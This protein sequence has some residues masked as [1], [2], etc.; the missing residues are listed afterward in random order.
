MTTV[1][2]IKDDRLPASPDDWQSEDKRSARR[3]DVMEDDVRVI[4]DELESSHMRIHNAERKVESQKKALM[5]LAAISGS[6]VLVNLTL[7][8]NMLRAL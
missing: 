6:L 7:L 5:S 8:A 2:A 1:S 4:R 3:L